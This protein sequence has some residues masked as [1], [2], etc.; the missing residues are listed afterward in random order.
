MFFLRRSYVVHKDEIVSLSDTEYRVMLHLAINAGQWCSK[1]DIIAIVWP[2]KDPY[3]NIVA[4]Y[5]SRLRAKLGDDVIQTNSRRPETAYR[6]HEAVEGSVIT[7]RW[8][9]VAAVHSPDVNYEIVDIETNRT[10]AHIYHR[11][12][13]YARA[14]AL[15]EELRTALGGVVEVLKG[16]AS[17]KERQ[18][19][20]QM[21][22]DVLQLVEGTEN[23]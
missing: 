1:R 18:F 10:I 21:A 13:R 16:E 17:T 7:P 19:S 4:D 23:K 11:N 14:C 12:P 9:A 2:E 22:E 15:A 20:L 5:V 8:A 6:T 3:E